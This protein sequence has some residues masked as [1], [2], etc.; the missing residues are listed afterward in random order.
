[1]ENK[2]TFN[3]VNNEYKIIDI[4]ENIKEESIKKYH[5]WTDECSGR[6]N[7]FVN[8][9]IRNIS[10]E[11]ASFIAG[12][13][14]KIQSLYGLGFNNE[15]DFK[16]RESLRKL[17]NNIVDIIYPNNREICKNREEYQNNMRKASKLA[18]SLEDFFLLAYSLGRG[19]KN[20]DDENFN[21]N[22][23]CFE[24][25]MHNCD[26]RLHASYEKGSRELILMLQL[27]LNSPEAMKEFKDRGML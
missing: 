3:D 11:F 23:T 17:K 5:E 10:H 1:M 15:Y 18:N 22:E 21:M 25:Y 6:K 19:S 2:V 20:L 9:K 7:G 16:H 27:A 26:Q 24:E 14:S 12:L 4:L 8:D 13:E